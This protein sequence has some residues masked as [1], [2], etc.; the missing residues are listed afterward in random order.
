MPPSAGR[1]SR[2]DVMASAQ[3]LLFVFLTSL[4][5]AS[6]L[7]EARRLGVTRRMLATPVRAGTIILGEALGRFAISM[8][9]GVVIMGGSALIFWV[10]WGNGAVAAVLLMVSFALLA[11]GAGLLMGAVARIT[12]QAVAVGRDRAPRGGR[13]APPSR[14]D[15]LIPT[16]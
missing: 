8:F 10:S 14:P 7:I 12:E 11:S 5:G 2:F 4:T 6:A 9:Q 15:G 3:L 16:P 13:L 1:A